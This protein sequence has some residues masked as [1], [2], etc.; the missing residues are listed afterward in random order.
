M[1]PMR[2]TF[3]TFAALLSMAGI[4][5]AQ[6]GY[7]VQGPPPAGAGV[8]GAPQYTPG[9]S[10]SS[11]AYA[12]ANPTFDPNMG[13]GTTNYGGPAYTGQQQNYPPQPGYGAAPVSAGMLTYG[14]LE[15]D[16]K[17]TTYSDKKLA[18][19]DGVAISLMTE[20][21]HPFFLHFGADF[22]TGTE[23]SLSAKN[24]DMST[25]TL[26][27]GGFFAITNRLHLTGEIGFLYSNL[28]T[29]K[30][31]LSFSDGAVYMMPGVRFAATDSLELDGHLTATSADKYDSFIFDLGGYYKI[32]AQMDLGL[33]VGFGDQ[34]TTYKAGVRFRW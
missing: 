10:P 1:S 27:G 2:V 6:Y 29:S 24:Y 4:A 14:Q 28:S 34:S 19:S 9:Y 15:V 21:F 31:N 33:N 20:L 25:F 17:R 32:F 12:P 30:S 18:A 8:G 26:G 16:Y 22:S 3:I 7:S 11:P 5:S 13:M 23:K